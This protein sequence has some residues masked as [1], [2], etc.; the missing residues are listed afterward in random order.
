MIT[1]K[2]MKQMRTSKNICGFHACLHLTGE[3][4][5]SHDKQRIAREEQALKVRISQRLWSRFQWLHHFDCAA[6]PL[7]MLPP[8]A[9]K[10]LL[11]RC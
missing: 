11:I 8:S 3:P 5:T 2:S 1:I 9:R 4:T 7:R 6:G 10:Q